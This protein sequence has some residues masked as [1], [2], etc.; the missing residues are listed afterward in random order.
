MATSRAQRVLMIRWNGPA[1][2]RNLVTLANGLQRNGWDV[3]IASVVDDPQQDVS[4]LS[5]IRRLAFESMG[6]G[7]GRSLAMRV[8]RLNW[9]CRVLRDSAPDLIYVMDSWTLPLFI[10]ARLLAGRSADCPWVYHTVDWI[11]PHRHPVH[12][13][14]E[15]WA[16][17]HAAR[18]INT[19]RSRARMQQAIYRLK[20]TP[21]FMPNYLSLNETVPGPDNSLRLELLPGLGSSDRQLLVNP[22]MASPTRMVLELIRALAATD[23]RI[24]LLQFVVDSTYGRECRRLVAD[25]HLENRVHFHEPVSYR[26]IMRMVACADLGVIFH[27]HRPS[28]GYFMCNADRLG[29]YAACG[30]PCIASDYPNMEALVYRH[31]LGECC[32]PYDPESVSVTLTRMMADPERLAAYRKRVREAFQSDLNFE[33]HGGRLLEALQRVV[34]A[35]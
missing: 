10:P 31:G 27:D 13:W 19:D 21:L 1:L 9:L 23:P 25:L 32:N 5:S 4:L 22:T 6:D 26:D 14:V 15:R 8:R 2:F 20:E 24:C 16:C 35:S 34:A 17:H 29:L 30:L 33:A 12:A 18:V 11:E 7:V 3:T 28:S